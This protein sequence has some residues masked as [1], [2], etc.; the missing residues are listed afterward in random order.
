MLDD[1][2][3]DVRSVTSM[4]SAV[5]A[6][7]SE[8][9]VVRWLLIGV[10]LVFL[11]LFLVLPLV[12]VFAQAFER[13]LGAYAGALQQRAVVAAIQLTLLTAIVAVPL[14]LVFGVTA[15]WAITKF[16]FP[17]KQVL[18]T[19]IDLP[20]AVSPVISGL[21]YVLLFGAQGFLGP[22]LQANNWKIIFTPLGIILATLFVS[23][24]FVAR[25]LIPVMEAQGRDDEEAAVSLGASGWQTFL[26][27]TLPNVTWGLV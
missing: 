17:G 9:A 16:D 8:P 23:V 6:T 1:L 22:W 12:A 19:L 24:P 27:V 15:A 25:E 11:T 5:R 7:P 13:G 3:S 21:V 14:N 18:I 10:A 20:F 2:R 4:P 26:R